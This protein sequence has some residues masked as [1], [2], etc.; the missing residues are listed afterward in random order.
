MLLKYYLKKMEIDGKNI[1]T[2]PNSNFLTIDDIEQFEI[3]SAFKEIDMDLQCPIPY[4]HKKK[5]K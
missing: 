3:F 4:S 5:N 1:K 2:S